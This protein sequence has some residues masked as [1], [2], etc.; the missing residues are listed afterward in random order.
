MKPLIE[1][2]RYQSLFSE[3]KNLMNWARMASNDANQNEI[4]RMTLANRTA[5]GLALKDCAILL[6]E[7]E[8][9]PENRLQILEAA[10]KLRKQLFGN[11]VSVMAPLEYSSYCASSCTFCGW[12]SEN[13]RATRLRL[14][15]EGLAEETHELLRMGFSHIEISGGDDIAFLR[16]ELPNAVRTVKD[17]ATKY[18][19]D[20]RVSICLT[21]LTT[22]LYANLKN[23]DGLDAV[24]TWQETYERETFY[25]LVKD[26]PKRFGVN[27]DLVVV[28]NGDG[29][30]ERMRSQEYAIR[31]GLQVGMG[32][33]LGIA[34]DPD[35]DILT[36]INHGQMLITHYD[37]MVAPIIFG[38]PLW[39]P[40]WTR[41]T[42]LRSQFGPQNDWSERFSLVA[43]IYLLAMP[44]EMAWVFPN[45]RVSP[46]IQIESILA[47]GVFTSTQVKVTPGGYRALRDGGISPEVKF[48]RS[49]CEKG[50]INKTTI[51]AGEQF[52]H[53]EEPH[54]MYLDRFARNGLEIVTDKSLLRKEL[55]N[56]VGLP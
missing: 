51:L 31:A 42:D 22:K 28:T 52:T 14:S 2:E 45:C 15:A 32:V 1:I 49:S 34:D 55:P 44:D 39:R 20:A 53:F 8:T 24:L 26:G 43:A 3:S 9:R 38:M 7:S 11:R 16:T 35:S 56:V 50:S 33:M 5:R 10:S 12:R 46:G 18:N 27:D 47:A 25:K 41:E 19:R 40:I 6:S 17:I 13:S 54:Q 23:E 4:V 37:H 29:H 48:K 30:L 21:P 36:C